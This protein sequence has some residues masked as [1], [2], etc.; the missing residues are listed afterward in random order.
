[1]LHNKKD[2][3]IFICKNTG[4][5]ISTAMRDLFSKVDSDN[6]VLS[7]KNIY[8]KDKENNYFKINEYQNFKLI[9]DK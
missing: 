8:L 2:E 1:M 3:A 9:C 4:N 6:F 7:F 5:Y